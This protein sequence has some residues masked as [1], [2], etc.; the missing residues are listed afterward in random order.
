MTTQSAFEM[1]DE[2]FLNADPAQFAAAGAP[3]EEA[4]GSE[5]QPQ[6]G[7][8]ETPPTPAET[9]EPPESVEEPQV[10]ETEEGGEPQVPDEEVPPAADPAK[11]K[12]NDKPVPEKKEPEAP[13]EK[14]GAVAAKTAEQ[15]AQDYDRLMA[16]FKANGRDFQVK[17]VDEAVRLMQMGANY[18]KKMAGLKPSLKILKMLENNQLLDESK[19]SFLI[20]IS[21]NDQAAIQKLLQDN[22]IDPLSIDLENA[23]KYT[24]VSHA[25]SDSSVE[26]DQVLDDVQASPTGQRTIQIVA[27]QWDE[28]SKR[29]LVENPQLINVINQ[30]V[31]SGIYDQINTEVERRRMLGDL[32]NVSS[33]EAYKAVGD[34]MQAQGLLQAQPAAQSETPP[35]P[36]TTRVKAPTE[37]EADRIAA[38]KAK[39]AAPTKTTQRQAKQEFNPLAMSDEEFEKQF[40]N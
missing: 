9:E 25:V 8:Q 10:P 27:Q 18:N 7:E 15:K 36:V 34:E 3:V 19:L 28:P 39:A 1:S 20:D 33:I 40:S 16:P 26:L 32:N 2:D 13:A 12:L 14:A 4:P 23:P 17:N 24:P 38:A 11:A 22:K 6:P 31:A 30:Q 5:E 29:I 21:K 37:T 35:A